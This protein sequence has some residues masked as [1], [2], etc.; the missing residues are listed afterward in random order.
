MSGH[1]PAGVF[2]VASCLV[3]ANAVGCGKPLGATAS[4]AQ[5]ATHASTTSDATASGKFDP[6]P[7]ASAPDVTFVLNDGYHLPLASLRGKTV[8]VY[9]CS[10]TAA[11]AAEAQG[12]RAH[13]RELEAHHVVVLGVYEQDS[14]A[15][16]ALAAR[17]GVSFDLVAD[18]DGSIAREFSVSVR[19]LDAP[20]VFVIA[21]NGTVRNVW[22]GGSAQGH[23]REILDG[24]GD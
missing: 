5:A 21:P 14:A 7:G 2:V 12:F 16:R 18:P 13:S 15:T 23:A 20:Y 3:L 24:A 19:D 8:A 17:E 10:P 4:E 6:R 22:P 9:L 1:S 11:C